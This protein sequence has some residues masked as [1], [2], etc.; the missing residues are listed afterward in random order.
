MR[1]RLPALPMN[2]GLT[3]PLD[4]G[5]RCFER[6]EVVTTAHD[7]IRMRHFQRRTLA[8]ASS[9]A[10]SKEPAAERF[11]LDA[12]LSRMFSMRPIAARRTVFFGAGWYRLGWSFLRGQCAVRPEY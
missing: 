3:C 9:T 1:A 8:I 6:N 4:A 11:M 7:V 12:A 10:A 2:A 5:M